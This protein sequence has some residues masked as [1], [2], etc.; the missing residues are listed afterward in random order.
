MRFPTVLFH[1]KSAKPGAHSV[2]GDRETPAMD[3]F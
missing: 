3:K 1:C 2:P